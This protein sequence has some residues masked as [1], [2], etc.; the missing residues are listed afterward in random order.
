MATV[1]GRDAAIGA[2]NLTL[3]SS[4]P[5]ILADAL[6][7]ARA[8]MS[9]SRINLAWAFGCSAI[10]IPLAAVGYPM[11]SEAPPVGPVAVGGGAWRRSGG[12]GPALR[13]GPAHERPYS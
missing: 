5:R 8:T 6:Q 1:T 4:D 9:V 10:A 12:S 7:L 11:L 2:A 3:V 13:C